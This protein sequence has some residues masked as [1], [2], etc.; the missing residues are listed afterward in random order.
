LTWASTLSLV[1]V[2]EA[3]EDRLALDPSVG[4]PGGGVV[5]PGRVQ[6]RAAMGSSA[7]VVGL[8]LGHHDAQV[9]LAEYQHPVGDLGPRGE[10]EP[11]RKGV[12]ARTSGRDLHGLDARAG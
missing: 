6:L 8:V 3:A 12:G 2:D 11:L 5:G 9:P 1:F 7:V 10:H 4:K